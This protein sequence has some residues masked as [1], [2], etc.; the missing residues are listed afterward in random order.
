MKIKG[1][2]LGSLFFIGCGYPIRMIAV[3]ETE[4]AIYGETEIRKGQKYATSKPTDDSVGFFESLVGIFNSDSARAIR[5]NR[6]SVP[7]PVLP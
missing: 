5:E 4:D 6:N 2:L 3:L 7:S 1:I